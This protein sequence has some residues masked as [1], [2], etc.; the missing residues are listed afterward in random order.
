MLTYKLLKG[1]TKATTIVNFSTQQVPIKVPKPERI[2]PS[3]KPFKMGTGGRSSFSGNVITVFGA[4]GYVGIP[5]VN[6]LA[7]YGN[8][9]ILPYRCDP[10]YVRELKISGDLGQILF[11]PFNLKDENA[12]RKAVRHS[13]VVIN[14]IGTRI[15]S[16]Y[17]QKFIFK[18]YF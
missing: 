1:G 12:I 14:L 6:R 18:S 4:N 7:K 16:K 15:N 3:V 13:N 2:P 11:F 8:Q 17:V 5:L 10:Y 9:L